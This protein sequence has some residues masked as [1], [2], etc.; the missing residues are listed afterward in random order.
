MAA[1]EI[2]FKN[3]SIYKVSDVYLDITTIIELKVRDPRKRVRMTEDILRYMS[4]FHFYRDVHCEIGS[5]SSLSTL[6]QIIS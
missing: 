3:P 1:K 6:G 2:T 5:K 4:V